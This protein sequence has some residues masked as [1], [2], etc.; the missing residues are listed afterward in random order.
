MEKTAT[1]TVIVVVATKIPAA[2]LAAAKEARAV[3]E[4]K[5]ARAL[6]VLVVQAI[7]ITQNQSHITQTQARTT[8]PIVATTQ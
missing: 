6:A 7:P 1:V 2:V 4:A 3:R 5:E 8:P